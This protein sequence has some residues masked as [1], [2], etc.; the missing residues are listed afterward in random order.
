MFN[1][2]CAQ[3]PFGVCP[4]AVWSV[5]KRTLIFLTFGA[6]ERTSKMLRMG[7][8]CPPKI[9]SL[10]FLLCFLA[11]GKVNLLFLNFFYAKICSFI[12]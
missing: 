12:T 6:S 1:K 4:N 3:M 5:L 11:L 8:K 2:N 10:F 9:F 7:F